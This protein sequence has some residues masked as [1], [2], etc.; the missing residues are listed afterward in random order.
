VENPYKPTAAPLRDPPPPP[1]SPAVAILAGLGVDLGG[2]ILSSFVLGIAYAI[3]L[4]VGGVGPQQIQTRLTASG[5]GSGFFIVE[6]IVGYAFS[7]LGGYVCARLARR[8]DLRVTWIMAAVSGAVA[9]VMSGVTR[10]D[11]SLTIPLTV[12]QVACVMAGG[13]LGRRRNVTDA[14]KAA[15]ATAG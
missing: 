1:R 4:A 14:R 5:P 15:A 8:S 12:V 10:F 6:T 11:A 7:L 2:S 9:L 3:M 13:E